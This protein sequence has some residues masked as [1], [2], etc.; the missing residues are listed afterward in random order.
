MDVRWSSARLVSSRRI[1]Q[2]GESDVRDWSLGSRRW[3]G[4]FDR[5]RSA[6]SKRARAGRDERWNSAT[7]W[8]HARPPHRRLTEFGSGYEVSFPV[9]S[10]APPP[11][12]STPDVG[13]ARFPAAC[14]RS[15]G[16]PD[17]SL[18][19]VPELAHSRTRSAR[20][21]RWSTATIRLVTAHAEA[22]H[23]LTV[24]RVCINFLLSCIK[25]ENYLPARTK[26]KNENRRRA[27]LMLTKNK[28]G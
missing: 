21:P 23:F 22:M 12:P 10:P 17:C 26:E 19:A 25:S 2:A 20:S 15:P 9:D 7:T 16:A 24:L 28:N 3:T 8:A 13:R 1:T 4:S 6:E 5:H 27:I 18:L 14:A 11:V